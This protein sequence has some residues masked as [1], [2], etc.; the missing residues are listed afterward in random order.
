[1]LDFKLVTCEFSGP[2][3]RMIGAGPVVVQVSCK[4]LV[5]DELITVP[6]LSLCT[7]EKEEDISAKV[8]DAIRSAESNLTE[9][10]ERNA[11]VK[12][13]TKIL[14][15]LIRKGINEDAKALME[16]KVKDTP[17]VELDKINSVLK[18]VPS[19]KQVKE[20]QGMFDHLG[21]GKFDQTDYTMVEVQSLI[22]ELRKYF[23]KIQVR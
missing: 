9:L 10:V 19:D 21:W 8:Q 22:I 11:K 1:M 15:T 16:E 3:Q 18:G 12:E 23:T 20:V 13:G 14:N 17:V 7:S 6:G 4:F 2:V 5:Q